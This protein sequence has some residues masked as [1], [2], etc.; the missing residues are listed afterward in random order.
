MKAWKLFFALAA[1]CLL[2]GAV[3]LWWWALFG[4]TQ[5]VATAA[6][7]TSICGGFLFAAIGSFCGLEDV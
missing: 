3:A 7:L 6:G 4:M 5:E 1:L 2:G